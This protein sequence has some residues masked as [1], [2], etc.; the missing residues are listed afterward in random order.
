M[1]IVTG[2]QIDVRKPDPATIHILDIAHGLA[3]T[4]R[5]TG[6]TK[7]HYSVA[8]HSLLVCEFAKLM[9]A[10]LITQLYALLHDA[11]EGLIGDIISPVKSLP[12]VASAY[13]PIEDSFMDI[14]WTKYGSSGD[15]DFALVDFADDEVLTLEKDTVNSVG[16]TGNLKYNNAQAGRAWLDKWIELQGAIQNARLAEAKHTLPKTSTINEIT[17]ITQPAIY[18]EMWE[19]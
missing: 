6:Q 18:G 2:S 12:E 3:N 8:A 15:V 4:A 16:F 14:I 19:D 5:F 7:P 13:N 11:P 9:G 10:S 17:E 1:G